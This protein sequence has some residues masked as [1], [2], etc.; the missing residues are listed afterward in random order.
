MSFNAKPVRRELCNLSYFSH[1]NINT[2][3]V[4]WLK[5]PVL[6]VVSPFP[7]DFRTVD[8]MNKTVEENRKLGSYYLDMPVT[9]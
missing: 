5:M 2:W 3:D 8:E 6:P 7:G 9:P 1:S 4:I